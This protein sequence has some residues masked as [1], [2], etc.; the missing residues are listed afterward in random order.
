MNREMYQTCS[1]VAAAKKA[2]LC[3]TTIQYPSCQHENTVVFSFLPEKR[4]FRTRKYVAPDVSAWFA[5]MTKKGLKDIQFLCPIDVQNRPL[6]GFSNMT[7]SGILCFSEDGKVSRFS[8]DWQFDALKNQWNTFY[9]E[10]D[11]ACPPPEKPRFEDNS[12]S[13]RQAL[14]EIQVLAGKLGFEDFA[15]V[16]ETAKNI[17]D[18]SGEYPDKQYYPSLPQLP[19]DNLR[20]FEAASCADVFGAMG[21]WNDSPAYR[22]DQAGLAKEYR[23][24]SDELLKNVRLALLFSV[25]EW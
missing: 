11:L 3:G 17:L 2:I 24:L 12:D 21:S 22:A 4:L 6:L 7:D 1:I 18:G 14:S 19:P 8:P 23:T 13:L 25:N 15:H 16:F 9:S 20:I 10:Y 5:H